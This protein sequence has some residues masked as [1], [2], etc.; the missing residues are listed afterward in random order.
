M[1]PQKSI[2]CNF[3]F[4]LYIIFIIFLYISVEI[5]CGCTFGK[6]RI[7]AAVFG[8]SPW[9]GWEQEHV[10]FSR[11]G[12][13][14]NRGGK[15]HCTEIAKTTSHGFKHPTSY[16]LPKHYIVNFCMYVCSMFWM[17]FFKLCTICQCLSIT[18][19]FFLAGNLQ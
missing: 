8:E 17:Q 4:A 15:K 10:P 19:N 14:F 13:V 16:L 5:G 6:P 1:L 2:L 7:C 11:G 12:R 18:C 3:C 9:F